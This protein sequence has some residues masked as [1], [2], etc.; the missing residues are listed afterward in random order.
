MKNILLTIA[1]DGTNFFGWQK[2]PELRT[3]QGELEKVLS[4]I[5]DTPIE[6]NGTGR[7]D[8]GVH[9]LGQRA[10]FKADFK[11]PVE[12][13]P[14]VANRL[15]ADKMK[16][17]DVQ[18]VDIKEVPEDFHARFS[19]KG[20]EYQYHIIASKKQNVFMRNRAYQLDKKLDVEA[21]RTAAKYIV[22]THDFNC[23]QT[24]SSDIKKT[25][26]R[27][28]YHL[29]VIEKLRYQSDEDKIEKAPFEDKKENIKE[30][31]S[32]QEII[33]SIK[34][35]GFLYNMVRII[36]G[37]LVEV[38]LGKRK[39]EDLKYIIESKNRQNAGHTA[40]PWGLYMAEVYFDKQALC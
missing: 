17:A 28:I 18:I 5:C 37:T 34:G 38:G 3:V 20:K 21:M 7:T 1:Y 11:I 39:P 23:F 19:A 2:Q 35:D 13:I 36:S 4:K 29:D 33:L 32:T 9:A 15:L 14:S 27:T 6:L 22:G 31:L 10:S 30:E 24:S 16:I 25:T 40:P 12:K 8:T 26:V